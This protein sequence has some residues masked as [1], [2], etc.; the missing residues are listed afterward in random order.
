[1]TLEQQN[2][3]N[4]QVILMQHQ[5]FQQYHQQMMHMMLHQ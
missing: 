4:Q 2:V 3:Y 1:M 5:A